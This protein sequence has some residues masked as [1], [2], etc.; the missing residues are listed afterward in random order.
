MA[1]HKAEQIM[2]AAL[3]AVTGLA[4]TGTQVYRGRV[5]PLSETVSNA[6][7]LYQGADT[8]EGEDYPTSIR[9]LSIYIDIHTKSPTEQVET[10]LNQISKEVSIA[11][12]ATRGLGLGFV[13]DVEEVGSDE[14]ELSGDAD[15]PDAKQRMTWHIEYRRMTNDP[16]Q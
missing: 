14:P 6:L 15:Q 10:R 5:N 1:D 2:V 16:S 9:L 13:I 4:T 3:A 11:M 8:K 12:L 7:S